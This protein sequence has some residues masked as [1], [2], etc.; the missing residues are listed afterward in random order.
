M[1][2]FSINDLVCIVFLLGCV[3]S[4]IIYLFQEAWL[5]YQDKNGDKKS[6][7]VVATDREEDY[8]VPNQLRIIYD[9]EKVLLPKFDNGAQLRII[10]L[11]C[12]TFWPI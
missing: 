7:Q 5:N 4:V 3:V 2:Y 1:Q 12:L 8:T 6:E 10:Y 9:F 11:I